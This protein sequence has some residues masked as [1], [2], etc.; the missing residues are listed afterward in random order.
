MS[1]TTSDNNNEY[2]KF[3]HTSGE[4]T[5][6]WASIK[7]DGIRVKGTKVSLEGH[8]HSYLPL[9]GG[10]LSLGSIDDFTIKKTSNEFS[11]IRFTG[12]KN[13]SNTVFGY[14]GFM[15]VN[16]PIFRNTSNV[17]YT[18]YH[19]VNL[20]AYP[21]KSSWNYDDVY[22]KS[23]SI[24]GNNLRINKN[25]TNTDLTIPYASNADTVDSHHAPDLFLSQYVWHDVAA[26]N[27]ITTKYEYSDNGS[28]FTEASV[29][30]VANLFD[31]KSTTFNIAGHKVTRITLKPTAPSIVNYIIL[32]ATYTADW[33]TETILIEGYGGYA[34][35]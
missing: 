9:S 22:V 8:T 2:F 12:L 20:P 31:H 25:G 23:V 6:E 16:T 4:T 34:A 3:S 35:Q 15:D 11:V 17:N 26:Y 13:S 7:S 19:S 24:S 32:Q 14:L 18:L 30:L 29:D 33:G 10:I 28:T 27:T 5:T 1:F 21:T